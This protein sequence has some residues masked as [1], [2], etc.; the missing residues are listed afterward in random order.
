MN[1]LGTTHPL[2]F[3]LFGDRA[4]HA[5]VQIHML[6]LH[7]ADLDAPGVGLLIED[8]LDIRIELLP[9][10]QHL[11]QFVLAQHRAQG[12]LRQLAGGGEKILHLNDRLV[13]SDH[14]KID[15]RVHLD[16]NVVA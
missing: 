10:G 6:D 8:I 16:R 7:I 5:L 14:T 9:L 1:H 15:H 4:N 12:G 11:I 3:G 2:G 13:G